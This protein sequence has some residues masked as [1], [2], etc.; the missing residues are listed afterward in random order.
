MVI[1]SKF[2]KWLKDKCTSVTLKLGTIN[3]EHMVAES[4]G[5]DGSIISILKVQRTENSKR[6]RPDS[7]LR[8]MNGENSVGVENHLGLIH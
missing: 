4:I 7:H 8:H 6:V 3:F 5:P 1:E 2:Q